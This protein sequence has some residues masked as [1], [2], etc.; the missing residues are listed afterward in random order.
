MAG[1]V[2]EGYSAGLAP[3]RIPPPCNALAFVEGRSSPCDIV[4]RALGTRNLSQLRCH[5]GP[6]EI[7]TMLTTG[8]LERCEWMLKRESM[9]REMLM[10]ALLS[11]ALAVV[12]TGFDNGWAEFCNSKKMKIPETMMIH[13][14]VT[15]H[16][17]R[18]YQGLQINPLTLT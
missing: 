7:L 10:C 18:A 15:S 12:G 14:V 17:H 2:S 5:R 11:D 9:S 6:R 8:H 3:N 16:P 4:Y 1:Y 13:R